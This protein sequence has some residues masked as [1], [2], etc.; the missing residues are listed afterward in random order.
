MDR[1]EQERSDWV[2]QPVKPEDTLTPL[3]VDD[4][5]KKGAAVDGALEHE[6]PVVDSEK[7]TAVPEVKPVE[8]TRLV[9]ARALA[10]VLRFRQGPVIA[11]MEKNGGARD[12]QGVLWASWECRGAIGK[13]LHLNLGVMNVMWSRAETWSKKL[14]D[15]LEMV[16]VVQITGRNNVLG[17]EILGGENRGQRTTAI[18]R[19]VLLH[20]MQQEVVTRVG[21][22]SREVWYGSI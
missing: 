18:C 21:T 15:G 4:S 3:V 13:E 11:A 19:D 5:E 22:F 10:E 6:G 9:T 1:I 16:K 17:C 8:R 20:E 12:A 14:P 7:K 2:P